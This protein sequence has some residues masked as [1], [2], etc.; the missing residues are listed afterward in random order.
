LD[1]GSVRRRIV[2][3]TGQYKHRKYE[4]YIHVLGGIR[5]NDPSGRPSEDISCLM[6]YSALN[7]TY[8]LKIHF[9]IFLPGPSSKYFFFF[10]KMCTVKLFIFS[11]VNILHYDS[12]RGRGIFKYSIS[13]CTMLDR[14][15]SDE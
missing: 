9:N 11:L 6:S 1:K 8:Y 4:E 10:R 2:S 7:T 14:R 3:Y 5:T 15:M 12:I 13:I